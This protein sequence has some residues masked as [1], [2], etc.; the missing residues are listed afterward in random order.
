M[1]VRMELQVLPP[2][3]EDGEEANLG[4]K[5]LRVGSYF[6]Q[7]VGGCAEQQTVDDLLIVEREPGQLMW[8]REDHVEVADRKTFLRPFGEPQVPRMG[9]AL[10][11]MPRPARVIRDVG[12]IAA[13]G[14]TVDVTAERSRAAML[15]GVKDSQMLI[16]QPRTVVLDEGF[17]VLSND[18]RH[19]E[20]WLIHD[21]FCS[22]R[23]RFTLSG[24][25][26]SI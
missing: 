22:F 16:G 24:L 20:R 13:S 10:R 5:P 14:T 3:V 23:E 19:L 1:E 2:T 17:P 9:E 18:I 7:S 6:E 11:A 21:R 8:Q 4:S 26:T 25:E 15:D 12:A